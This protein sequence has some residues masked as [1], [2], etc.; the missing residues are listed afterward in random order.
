MQA[1]ETEREKSRNPGEAQTV[2]EASSRRQAMYGLR[3][4]LCSDDFH[5]GD[6][7]SVSTGIHEDNLL[8]ECSSRLLI[9]PLVSSIYEHH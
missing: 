5:G 1:I 6:F 7:S 3:E 8:R 4:H 2:P 9:L